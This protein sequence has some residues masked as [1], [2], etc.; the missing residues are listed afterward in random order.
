MLRSER[1]A[2]DGVGVRLPPS[3]QQHPMVAQSSRSARDPVPRRVRNEV[4][5]A[6]SFDVGYDRGMA[7]RRTY[8][9]EQ[10]AD[11]VRNATCWADVMEALG[12]SRSRNAADVQAVAAKLGL[13]TVHLNRARTSPAL[14]I[15]GLSAVANTSTV[16]TR[17][18]GIVLAA[19]IRAGLTVLLPFGDGH[20]YDLAVDDGGK[21]VRVQCKTAVYRQGC[22]VFK[23]TSQR[24]DGTEYGY[25]GDADVFGVYCP[26]RDAVY[27]VPVG[28][29]TSLRVR[30]RVEHPR[31][32]RVSDVRYASDYEL[33][34]KVS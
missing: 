27:L 24:R 9:D 4:H 29:V 22:V 14:P 12:K 30:L 1:S 20:R 2:S 8:T 19:L 34:I 16:G 21:L 17:T 32:N 3:T 6:I 23:A 11:A 7:N 31:N 15:A 28:D 13:N 5:T 18:E 25:T 10:L 33:L 26:D